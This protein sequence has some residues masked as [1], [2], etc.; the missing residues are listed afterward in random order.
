MGLVQELS[1]A[2]RRWK[3]VRAVGAAPVPDRIAFRESLE[4][5]LGTLPALDYSFVELDAERPPWTDTGIELEAGEE[6]TL[7]ACGRVYMSRLLDVWV[8]PQ[9]QLWARVGENGEIFNGTRASHTFVAVQR[10]RLFLAGQFPGR[11][12]DRSGRIASDLRAYRKASGGLTVFAIRWNGAAADGLA[13]L[14]QRAEE[15]GQHELAAELACEAERLRN[16]PLPP[17]GWKYL[18]FLG[19]SDIYAQSGD[20]I[21][22]CTEGNVGI[23]QKDAALAL[24]PDTRLLWDWKVDALPSQTAENA[25]VAHD[26]LSIAV[27]FND[28]RDI[29]YHWSKELRPETGY[30]C[31]LEGWKDREYHVVV[32]SGDHGLGA[33]LSENRNLFEDY[34]MHIGTPPARIV[35]VWLIANSVFQR[36][37]GVCAY[38]GIR[39]STGSSQMVVC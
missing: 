17:P 6:V 13:R 38:R 24:T 32:R 28:G 39:L 25:V 18:W 21:T 20:T 8:G 23:L 37:R 2:A 1:A 33:W 29:T 10:G 4:G 31:P 9:F 7:L 26:Y 16:P 19:D 12:G 34:R 3:Q 35:R 5:V 15:G 14:R 27:E 36:R 30:W 11:W 22:C